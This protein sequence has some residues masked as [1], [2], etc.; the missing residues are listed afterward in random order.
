V[1]ALNQYFGKSNENNERQVK[2]IMSLTAIL[3]FIKI[4]F[5]LK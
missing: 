3:A 5:K 2:R 4:K 1:P